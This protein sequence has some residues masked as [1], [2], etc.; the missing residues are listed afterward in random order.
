MGR[1]ESQNEYDGVFTAFYTFLLQVQLAENMQLRLVKNIDQNKRKIFKRTIDYL[2]VII[3]V[4][5]YPVSLVIQFD[6]IL[7]E[8][9]SK[10]SVK[11]HLYKFK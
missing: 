11:V 9:C 10:V 6:K 8:L 7:R 4:K 1:P 5:K 3:I 2:W